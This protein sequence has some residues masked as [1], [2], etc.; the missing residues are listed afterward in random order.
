MSSSSDPSAKAS[1]PSEAQAEPPKLSPEG[2]AE[3]ARLLG[4]FERD[5]K[6][7]AAHIASDC[8]SRKII[9]PHVRDAYAA[10]RRCGLAPAPKYFWHRN[11]F[12][13]A[14]GFT[15]VGLSP[16][17][18]GLSYSVLAANCIP[19]DGV[20]LSFPFCF[21][22]FVAFLPTIC[23]VGGIIYAITGWIRQHR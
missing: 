17:I 22:F 7:I 8:C 6:G 20:L 18:S 13:I 10:L 9:E 14:A 3:A 11:D 16:S 5:L 21:W 2:R 1:L 23:G 19:G 15:A 12:R 4:D